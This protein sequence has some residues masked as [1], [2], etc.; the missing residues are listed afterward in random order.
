MGN[1]D[2]V[3]AGRPAGVA[4]LHRARFG[5]SDWTVPACGC[6]LDGGGTAWTL[7]HGSRSGRRLK[8]DK[9]G[10]VRSTGCR[11]SLWIRT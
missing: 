11:V 8:E 4:Y 10:V 9:I 1:V 6:G 7:D 2:L 5:I 3:A